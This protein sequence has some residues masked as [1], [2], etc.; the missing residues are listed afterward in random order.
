MSC[1]PPQTTCSRHGW[2]HPIPAHA[3]A[4]LLA[5]G[6]RVH[7]TKLPPLMDQHG[8]AGAEGL[9]NAQ[10]FTALYLGDFDEN[11]ARAFFF[12]HAL[13]RVPRAAKELA[14]DGAAWKHVYEVRCPARWPSALL[15]AAT[16]ATRYCT[17]PAGMRRQSGR[18]VARCQARRLY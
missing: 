18:A 13:S 3:P 5:I 1:L 17:G 11:T 6:V 16:H 7:C 15:A 10:F 12:E 8:N 9:L 14:A 4:R 2:A